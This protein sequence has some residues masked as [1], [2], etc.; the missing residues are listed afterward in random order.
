MEIASCRVS[1]RCESG[2][3][4]RRRPAEDF[5]PG[6]AIDPFQQRH[7]FLESPAWV[8]QTAE[9]DQGEVL[10]GWPACHARRLAP[11]WYCLAC[12][13]SWPTIAASTIAHR[14]PSTATGQQAGGPIPNSQLVTEPSVL[15][16][17]AITPLKCPAFRVSSLYDTPCA[18]VVG[19]WRNSLFEIHL[20][21]SATFPHCD[22]RRCPAG[23]IRLVRR[24]SQNYKLSFRH[25]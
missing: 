6:P 22:R 9:A 23:L 16:H 12:C 19:L 20:Y 13:R 24:C 5:R 25:F 17:Y 3:C 7:G 8:G 10:L 21:P 11:R 4:R 1:L 14:S 2:S 18:E 15:H